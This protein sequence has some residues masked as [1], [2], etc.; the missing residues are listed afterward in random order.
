MKFENLG[1]KGQLSL[2]YI[3]SSMIVI[4]IISLI[5]VPI[6]LTT[7]DYSNDLIDSINAKNE[8]SKITDAIDFCFTAGKGS[9]KII[10]VDFNQDINLK[11]SNNGKVGYASVNLNL[12]DNSKEIVRYFDYANLNDNIQ[13]SKGFNKLI[14]EWNEDSN[15]I[16]ITRVI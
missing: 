13:L 6:L 14:V 16:E 4:L 5:S 1:N 12:S 7:I 2:E 15:R 9:R 11:L 3:L 8:L 10:Y